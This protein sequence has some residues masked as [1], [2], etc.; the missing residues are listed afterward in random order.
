[1][2]DFAA[3]ITKEMEKFGNRLARYEVEYASTSS[4]LAADTNGS[5]PAAVAV[6]AP[7]VFTDQKE[8]ANQLKE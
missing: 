5:E 2:E 3:K 4:R 1:M 8:Q 6:S 7:T